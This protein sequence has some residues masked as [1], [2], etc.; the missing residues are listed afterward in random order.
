MSVGHKVIDPSGKVSMI[1]AESHDQIQD[2]V[3]VM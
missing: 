3:C 2:S 1:M